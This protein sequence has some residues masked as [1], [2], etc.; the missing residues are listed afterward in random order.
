MI[1]VDANLLVYAKVRSFPQHTAAHTW[2]LSAL[3][4]PARVGLPW[5]S[6]LAFA[7]LTTN[8]RIF[9]RPLSSTVA[10]DQVEAWLATPS[11]WV[12]VASE[13]HAAVLNRLMRATA[14]TAKT[15]PDAHLAALAIDHAL[16][17][18]TTDHG[19]GRFPGLKWRDPLR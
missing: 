17:L 14:A 16:E 8:P 13:R 4:G 11:V 7:R 2:L 1:L 15:V 5:E 12:P 18:A 3:A 10:W 9:E 19:F 6:L